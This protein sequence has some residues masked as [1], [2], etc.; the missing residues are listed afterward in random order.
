MPTC[1]HCIT[2]TPRSQI[3]VLRE[4]FLRICEVQFRKQRN[5]GADVALKAEQKSIITG[6]AL[7]L[8]QMMWE[9]ERRLD[10]RAQA[11][12]RGSSTVPTLWIPKSLREI[13][14]DLMGLQGR[15]YVGYSC[16]LLIEA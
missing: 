11:M 5:I 14:A 2:F 8:S 15:S 7:V 4:D 9:H 6:A 12:G 10:A 3:C 16:S 13:Q 1:E